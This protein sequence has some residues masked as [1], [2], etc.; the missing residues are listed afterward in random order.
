MGVALKCACRAVTRDD[1]TALGACR[2]AFVDAICDRHDRSA[3]ALLGMPVIDKVAL[4][5][6]A[7][8]TFDGGW[9]SRRLAVR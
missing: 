5:E 6:A 9:L 2:T 1:P 4:L 8:T 3:G 7:L